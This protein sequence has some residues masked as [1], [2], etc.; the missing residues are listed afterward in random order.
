MLGAHREACMADELQCAPSV[1]DSFRLD[2]ATATVM[3]RLGGLVDRP[4][5]GDDEA[6]RSDV[7]ERA[8]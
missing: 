3:Q 2:R 5:P 1:Q 7:C 8:R 6:V 4:G